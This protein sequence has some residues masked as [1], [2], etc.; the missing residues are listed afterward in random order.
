LPYN[1]KLE[2]IEPIALQN[3]YKSLSKFFISVIESKFLPEFSE[4]V[5]W[6]NGELEV[7]Q[8]P[9]IGEL[10]SYHGFTKQPKL[11]TYI[12]KNEDKSLPFAV[13]EFYFT[14]KVIV[15]II[16]LTK[17]DGKDFLEDSDYA[18]FWQTFQHFNKTDGWA[19]RDFSNDTK[20]K[21]TLNLNIKQ[22]KK[23]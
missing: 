15:F 8:L 6:I 10:I 3:I 17:K 18:N 9:K 7:T 14:C 5:K 21:L 4:T 12:R 16:P 13:G 2:T 11:V 1:I 19:F 23:E 20:R 22:E